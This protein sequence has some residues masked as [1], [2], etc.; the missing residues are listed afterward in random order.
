[1][2]FSLS[3]ART[4]FYGY[5]NKVLAEKLNIFMIVYLDDILI[6]IDKADHVDTIW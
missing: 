5:I 1:M 3:N 6:Y 4:S 2:L